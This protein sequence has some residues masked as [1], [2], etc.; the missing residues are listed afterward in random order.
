MTKHFNNLGDT[1][2]EVL[3]SI[4]ILSVIIVGAYAAANRSTLVLRDT[5]ER[6]TALTLAQNQVE[7]LIGWFQTNTSNSTN[8]IPSGQV[9]CFSNGL[10]INKPQSNCYVASDNTAS[11]PSAKL[12]SP[13]QPAYYY[14]I[15]DSKIISPVSYPIIGVSPNSCIITPITI[16]VQVTWQSLLGGQS[17][18]TLLYR[19]TLPPAC[20]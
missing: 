10:T 9:F 15:T 5:E 7:S 8:Q 12:T 11:A 16:M 18:V 13:T 2:I 14:T 20:G 19:P 6:T 4:A 17:R 1:I 3:I